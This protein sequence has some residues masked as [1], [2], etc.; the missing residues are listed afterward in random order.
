MGDAGSGF[1]SFTTLDLFIG[2]G[3]VVFAAII[4]KRSVKEGIGAE[5][6]TTIDGEDGLT[7][8]GAIALTLVGA[9]ALTLVGAIA[10]T[11]VGAIALMIVVGE[12][13]NFFGADGRL[14]PRSIKRAIDYSSS[15]FCI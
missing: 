15:I 10:L 9:I 13:I 4:C 6:L 8:V 7:L 1:R 5:G 2:G 11:L 3:K 12:A 14:G